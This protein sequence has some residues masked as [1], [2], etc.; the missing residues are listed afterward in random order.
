MR[1]LVVLLLTI[2]MLV[3]ALPVGASAKPVNCTEVQKGNDNPNALTG[4]GCD[5]T[6]YGF[7]GAD[8][9][10]DTAPKDHDSV[11]AGKGADLINVADGNSPNDTD[12]MDC[13]RGD[14]RTDTVYANANDVL[15]HCSKDH[16]EIR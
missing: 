12:L 2:A 1:K 14:H 8:Q 4:T 11:K 15:T 16:V 7:A 5:T 9:I 6:F 10:S 3:A 13:G